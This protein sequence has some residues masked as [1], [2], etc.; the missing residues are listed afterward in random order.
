[1]KLYIVE[2]GKLVRYERHGECKKCG[3]CCRKKITFRFEVLR[4][5]KPD[6]ASS[7]ED[8]LDWENFSVIFARGIYWYVLVTSIEDPEPDDEFVPCQSLK[9]NLCSIREDQFKIPPLCP[10]WPVHPKDLLP[11]CG[12]SF[13]K[14]EPE[15]EESN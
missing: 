13:E 8:W 7:P 2:N 11:G 14:C 6:E 3:A 15:D 1:M 9:D 12:Y 4:A 10:L 5:S